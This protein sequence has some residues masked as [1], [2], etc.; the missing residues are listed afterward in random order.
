MVYLFLCSRPI[1]ISIQRQ[2]YC[3][4]RHCIPFLPHCPSCAFTP[5]TSTSLNTSCSRSSGLSCSSS[6]SCSRSILTTHHSIRVSHVFFS[7]FGDGR[8]FGLSF[9]FVECVVDPLIECAS[10][11]IADS[12]DTFESGLNVLDDGICFICSVGRHDCS[13]GLV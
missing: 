2:P 6:T 5:I 4:S 8:I 13:F 12:T 7:L 10:H 11:G 3:A 1:S 9:R